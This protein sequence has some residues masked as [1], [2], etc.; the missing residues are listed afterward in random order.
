M[1]VAIHQPNFM[2]WQPFF[3][4]M[5]E[6][7]LFVL[8]THCQFEKNG[9]QNRFKIN[10]QWKT[11][12][13]HRGLTSIASKRYVNAR[14][15]WMAIKKSLP[16]HK[17]ILKALDGCVSNDL[18]ATNVALVRCLANMLSITTK[19]V[20]DGPTELTKTE[21]LVAICKQHGA[22]AY[23]SGVSGK[24]YLDEVLFAENDIEL[25]YQDVAPAHKRSILE[26]L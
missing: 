22:T 2:P 13:V 9:F 1:R 24:I 20:L 12:G 21:R 17:H 19:I 7:D 6:V 26:A 16:Q 3:E 25:R 8:L 14:R 4:K 10:N 18:T 11:M 5:R 15:D 23:L